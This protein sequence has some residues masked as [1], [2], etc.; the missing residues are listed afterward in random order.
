MSDSRH[1]TLEAL[2]FECVAVPTEERAALLDARCGDDDA[3]RAEVL[4]LLARDERSDEPSVQ[5]L[6]S[7]GEPA[8]IPAPLP[9]AIGPYRILERLGEGGFGEVFAA[10]QSAPVR[11]RVALKVL[12]AGMDSKAVLARFDAERQA[13]A[14][15]DHAGIAKVH[16]AGETE[17]GRPY[18]VMELVAGEAITDYC[19]RQSLPARERLALL[20]SVCRAV[21]HAHQKGV[22][23]RDLKPSNILVATADGAP[24]PKVID[25]G[26]AK[27][28]G[29]ALGDG[30]MH[31][32]QGEF[33]GTPE[34][35]SPEQAE[36][37]GADVD[38]R[39]DVYSLGVVLYRLL[40]GRLPFEP[41]RLRRATVTE[42]ARILREEDPPR[43]S[44]CAGLTARGSR[45][46]RGD[47]DWIVLRAMEKDRARRYPSA[48]ALADEIE[49]HLRDEPVLAGPPSTV[50]RMRKLVRRHRALV[51]GAAAVFITL[52][53]GIV[54]TTSQAIRARRAEGAAS[55]EAKT[56]TAV[57]AFLTRML[58]EAN[59][60]ENPR[61]SDVTVREMVDRAARELDALPSD[62]PRIEAGV[63]HTL[64]T[65]Y[66]GIGLYDQAEPELARALAIQER[67]AGPAAR[68]TI[69]T[70][71]AMAD[72]RVRR[73]EY[74]KAESLLAPAETSARNA[75]A[76]DPALW[77]AYLLIRG[78]ILGNM[79]RLDEGD[80]L[81]SLCVAMRRSN[82]ER[83]A[84]IAAALAELAE[85][86][87]LRGRLDEAA[88]LGREALQFTH[89]AHG[90]DH[91][92]VAVSQ[93]RLAGILRE[94]GT[95]AEAE[96][97]WRSSIAIERR[98]LGPAHPMTA[99]SIS[100]LGIV[101]SER[102]HPE[103]GVV[104]HREAFALLRQSLGEDHPE[105]ITILGNLASALQESGVYEEALTARLMV[106]DK[107][108]RLRAEVP[109][110]LA[111]QINNLGALYRLMGRPR[112]AEGA[113]REAIPLFRAAY[114]AEHPTVAIMTHNLGRT[115]IDQGRA[116]EAEETLREAIDL[117]ARV[118]P[119]GHI[120]RAIFGANH[121]RALTALGRSE[122]AE[123]AL[124][125]ARERIAALLGEAHPRALEVAGYLAAL[126]LK[127]GRPDEAARWRK[128]A[129]KS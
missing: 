37:G 54:T 122:E 107:K 3:L 76:A 105:T 83:P 81:L 23:H 79:G 60:E 34:Y 61:G 53:V 21:E 28:T 29:T 85:F 71:I 40:A 22:I 77:S 110:E 38:T 88:A 18:F 116:A 36:S 124:L 57:N 7:F 109:A 43:P 126:Y 27:A 106:I 96:S 118:F 48:A 113:F 42:M 94:L 5:P 115:L 111:T 17:A 47:L 15:M 69:E 93:G 56:A 86:R 8:T 104:C 33:L 74:A 129:E 128:A 6:V 90:D 1:R 108:R 4:D 63:R 91:H 78:G 100:N 31:T 95:Y 26:I 97:L 89:T 62:E 58:G 12:K 39:T 114:G 72:L 67:S 13:L 101:L 59:P 55:R 44:A 68:E 2:F 16:D 65:T 24:L 35:A 87:R 102:G 99:M 20:A 123:R 127:W 9:A 80:S 45:A 82:G 19:D 41:E 49:R 121:G 98:V 103:E 11:R 64:G 14:L 50:Y 30:T 92:D 51:A 66:M 10:E 117:A 125:P 46:L 73:G 119:E 75:G 32:R 112:D 120:N 70:L 25:F 84:A 52:V